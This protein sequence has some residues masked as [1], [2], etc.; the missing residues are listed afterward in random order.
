MV[1]VLKKIFT[2]ETAGLHQA[3]FLLGAFALLSQL[4]ALIRDKLLAASFGGSGMLDTY[5]AAFRIPDF[6]FVTLGSVVSLT[7]LIPFLAAVYHRGEKETR[8]FIDSIFTVFLISIVFVS[9]IIFFSTSFLVK[10]LFPGFTIIQA[11]EVVSLTRILLASPIL[12]GIS[13]LF[14][15]LT[16]SKG[17]FFVYAIS[18]IFYN[19]GII[20]GV[21]ALSPKLGL[22]GLAYGVILGACM[23]MLVQIPSVLHLNLFPR[24]IVNPDFEAIKKVLGASVPR[25]ITLSLSHIAVFFLLAIASLMS[26]GS[27]TV[28]SFAF[29]IQSVPLS[30]FGVSYSLAAFPALSKLFASGEKELFVSKILSSAQHIA[31]WAIPCSV[32]FIVLRAH[33]VRLVLGAGQFSWNDTKL[34]AALLALFSISLVFQCFILLF[35]RAL[36]ASGASGKPLAISIVS[37]ATTVLSSFIFYYLFEYVPQFRFFF[38]SIFSLADVPGSEAMM[39]ALGFTVGSI[40]DSGLLWL[41]AAKEWKGFSKPLFTSIYRITASSII[42]GFFSYSTLYILGLYYSLETFL[43]V[44][45]QMLVAALVGVIVFVCLMILLKAEE[46]WQITSLFKRKFMTSSTVSPDAELL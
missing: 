8:V 44:L 35:V 18:P 4:L 2:K 29:N 40:L 7:I 41:L 16:Q 5:Y 39:L 43:E 26:S 33:L 12:L 11:E 20:F 9:V 17:R 14:G 42:G 19:A 27:I 31:F 46:L 1:G 30:I 34:T 3:A 10:Y 28:F 22:S 37:G 23:H 36:Y 25:T 13:N 15:S 24:F 45:S 6:L 32:F 38:E 21:L